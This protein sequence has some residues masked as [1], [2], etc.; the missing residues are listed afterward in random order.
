MA[1]M[2]TMGDDDADTGMEHKAEGRRHQFIGS[3]RAAY[4]DAVG[5]EYEQMA[6]NF[7]ELRG[8]FQEKYG[9][10]KERLAE[11]FDNDDADDER[12]AA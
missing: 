8:K 10:A 1:G 3:I 11:F 5:D 7:E 4:G 6:G 12:M 9:D 2:N